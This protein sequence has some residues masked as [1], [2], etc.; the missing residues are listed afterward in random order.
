MRLL[1]SWKMLVVTIPARSYTPMHQVSGGAPLAA[2]HSQK[3][4]I[5]TGRFTTYDLPGR[6]RCDTAEGNCGNWDFYSKLDLS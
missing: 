4:E 1:G 6:L 3:R 2:H 5:P